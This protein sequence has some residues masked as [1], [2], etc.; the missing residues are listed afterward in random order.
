MQTSDLPTLIP[1]PFAESGTKNT[2]PTTP[3]TT[4]GLAS[5]QTGFPPVTMTPIVAG[6]IPPSGAD[7]NGILNLISATARWAQAGGGYRYNAG[8]STAVGGYP[9]GA[10]VLKANFSGY[11]LNT[12]ENNTSDPD[13]GGAGWTDLSSPPDASTTVKGIVQLATG[14]EA[15]AG[16]N[17]TKAITPATL[18]QE[19]N[20]K[21]NING[22]NPT[23]TS[24]VG[25][26]LALRAA[27]GYGSYV[28]GYK[29]SAESWYVGAGTT[30][31]D[32]VLLNSYIHNTYLRLMID[33]VA[34]NRALYVGNNVVYHAGN[35]PSAS[36]TERGIIQ[37]ATLAEANA[38]TNA[39]KAV[40][41]SL[42]RSIG[43]GQTWTN[44][45][46]SRATNTTYTNTTAKPIYVIVC[47]NSQ[48]SALVG[49]IEVLASQPGENNA[50]II[51]PPGITYGV[52]S[53]SIQRWSE[54]R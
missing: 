22:G 44:V 47:S 21:L 31:T 30:T 23:I 34:V 43:I 52:V 1:V 49:G 15:E 50:Y 20:K 8:F 4:P 39:E 33:R 24:T 46:G 54:L 19:T 29:G 10:M 28:K 14:A 38:G 13:A 18:K 35:L 16:T 40:P 42:V 17:N 36:T 12:L 25:I 48:I 53:T 6:G 11:W 32:D 9:R 5:L 2:I 51:V 3:P 41:P 27:D 45:T 26:E 37:I 7:F